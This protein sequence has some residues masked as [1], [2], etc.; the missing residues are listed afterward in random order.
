MI[1]GLGRSPGEGIGYPLQYSWASLVAQLVK[2]SALNA[3]DLGSITRLGRSP[4][5]RER[6]PTP[7][8]QPGEFHGLYS[9][10]GHKESDTTEQIS[11]SLNSL[12]VSLS[13]RPFLKFEAPSQLIPLFLFLALS[14]SPSSYCLLHDR[15]VNQ[16]MSCWEKEWRLIWKAR[17]S[18]IMG[19]SWLQ[20][21]ILPELEFRLLLY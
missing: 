14:L 9:L 16:V 6:L 8:F 1:P 12:N 19:D 2:E 17:K 5:R 21:T 3:G 4:W 18:R 13:M 20:R 10:W 11:F 15:P 7:V